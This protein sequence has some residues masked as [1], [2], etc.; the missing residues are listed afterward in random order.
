MAL[1]SGFLKQKCQ[2]THTTGHDEFGQ[3]TGETV[4]IKCRWEL[5]SGF[6]RGLMGD[7][8]GQSGA[9]MYQNK[10]MVDLSIVAGDTLSYTDAN[11]QTAGGRVISVTS[12]INTAGKEEGR[13]CY[14]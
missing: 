11:G 3:P 12:I 14:V 2:W 4:T 9:V 5:A 6:I 13:I 7:G 8:T 10:V 1:V